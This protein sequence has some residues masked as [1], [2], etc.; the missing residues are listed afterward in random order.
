MPT[1]TRVSSAISPELYRRFGPLAGSRL[2]LLQAQFVASLSQQS[3]AP[4]IGHMPRDG[5]K[6]CS[7]R[8]IKCDK[9]SPECV[10][11]LKKGIQCT[12][13]GRQIRF[14]E[15]AISKGKR[16]GHTISDVKSLATNLSRYMNDAAVSTPQS[17]PLTEPTHQDTDVE[18]AIEVVGDTEAVDTNDD[19]EEIGMDIVQRK[20]HRPI[21]APS[22]CMTVSFH[23]DPGAD[24]TLEL[25]KPG[26][27]M[28]FDHC[29]PTSLFLACLPSG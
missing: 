20:N 23:L 8:R 15:G 16:K 3:C 29:K 9:G 10:K 22:D 14:V 12:G 7:R 2:S 19:V 24:L 27:Q 28:L 11:C 25:L 18:T 21:R 17:E 13:V 26:I 4:I 6:E 5:C 1:L